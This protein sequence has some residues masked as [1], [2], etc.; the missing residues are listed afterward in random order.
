MMETRDDLHSKQ[1][2]ARSASQ[3]KMRRARDGWAGPRSKQAI[4]GSASLTTR[5]NEYLGCGG[6]AI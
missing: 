5:S 6:W 1:A 4:D 3:S 2:E